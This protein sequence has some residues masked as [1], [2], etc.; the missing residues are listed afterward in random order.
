VPHYNSNETVTFL[1]ICNN[2]E[3]LRNMKHDDYFSKNE[4]ESILYKIIYALKGH[5]F[6]DM[7]PESK[8]NNR[9]NVLYSRNDSNMHYIRYI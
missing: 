6:Q 3:V 7:S 2:Y 1:D 8:D 9:H 4:R 5:G